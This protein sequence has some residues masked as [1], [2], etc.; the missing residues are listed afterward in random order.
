MHL[1]LNMLI[2]THN[3]GNWLIVY[4]ADERVLLMYLCKSL[5]VNLLYTLI[6][7]SFKLIAYC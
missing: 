1:C 6:L 3:L 7:H 4:F 2:F 5:V